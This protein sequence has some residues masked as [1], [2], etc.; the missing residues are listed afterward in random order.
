MHGIP[1]QTALGR[2]MSSGGRFT[3]TGLAAMI[4]SAPLAGLTFARVGEVVQS[5]LA[6]SA[7]IPILM[8]VF[9][10][11][12][13]VAITR[14]GRLGHRP[15]I[16]SATVAAA[17]VAAVGNETG[18]AAI[19]ALLVAAASVAVVVPA[20]RVPYCDRCG[21]W[22][23][24]IRNGKIDLP[25]SRRLAELLDVDRPDRARSPRY[26]LSACRGDCGPTR[27]ELSWERSGGG[28]DLARVWLDGKQRSEVAAIV[29]ELNVKECE[30]A[31]RKEDCEAASG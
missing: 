21:S 6:P 3:W 5:Y 4:V 13:I 16:F 14:F 26:R 1:T 27:C 7:L 10:G 20:V 29:D 22:F 15:T 11:L 25:T 24:T 30:T 19:F 2:Q 9:I 12:T 28:V 17:V 18:D 8:G 23:R 31:K